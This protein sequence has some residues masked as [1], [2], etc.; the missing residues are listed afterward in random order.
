MFHILLTVSLL[1]IDLHGNTELLKVLKL[2]SV[3]IIA[4]HCNI[5]IRNISILQA[6]RIAYIKLFEKLHRMSHFFQ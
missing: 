5:Y 6:F 3:T 1:H 2:E 4:N